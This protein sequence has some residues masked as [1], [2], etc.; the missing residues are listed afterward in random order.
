MKAGQEKIKATV[1]ARQ[2]M[3]EAAMSLKETMKN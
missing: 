3:M 2:K 1:M